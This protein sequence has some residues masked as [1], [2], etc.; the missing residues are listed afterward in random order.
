MND[1]VESSVGWKRNPKQVSPDDN[2][3]GQGLC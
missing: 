2:G 3:Y 1:E